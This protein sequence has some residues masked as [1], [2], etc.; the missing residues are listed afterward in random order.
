M[1]Q[2]D[3]ALSRGFDAG[4]C[5]YTTDNETYRAQ[6]LTNSFLHL[7]LTPEGDSAD[8]SFSGFTSETY[9]ENAYISFDDK[10]WKELVQTRF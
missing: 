6:G 9:G 5:T 3:G 4:R 2:N 10:N 1:N 8:V 7:I